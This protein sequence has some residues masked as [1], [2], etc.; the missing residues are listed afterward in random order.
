MKKTITLLSLTDAVQKAQT[1]LV[2]AKTDDERAEAARALADAMDAKVKYSKRTRTDELEEDDGAKSSDP[3]SA[4]PTTESPSSSGEKSSSAEESASESAEAESASEEAEED[5]SKKMKSRAVKAMQRRPNMASAVYDALVDLTGEQDIN[6][7]VGALAGIK[8]TLS[9]H[10]DLVKRV[11]KIE[12]SSK[13]DRI[14]ALLT[15]ARRDGKIDRKESASL[16]A[17]GLKDEKWLAGYV[18][19]LAKGRVAKSLE[20]GPTAPKDNGGSAFASFESL[21]DES[22]KMIRASAAAAGQSVDDY[23]KQFQSMA[24]KMGTGIAGTH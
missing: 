5:A 2:G 15:K 23:F 11:R 1:A 4:P 14:D 7:A 12:S 20:D 22:K 8:A 13:S 3:D 6:R 24:A 18:G 9:T 10:A 19:G 17:M 21:D 16:R